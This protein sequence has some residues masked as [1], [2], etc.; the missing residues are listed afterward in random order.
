AKE[1]ILKSRPD[2]EPRPEVDLPAA[3]SG[4]PRE[5]IATMKNSQGLSEK[6]DKVFVSYSHKDKKLFEEFK[7]MLA[8]A[9]RDATV[10]LWDNTRI[11]PGAKWKEEIQMALGSAKV[12]V[13]LGE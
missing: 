5:S 13:L 2:Q 3:A 4:H 10:D 8:P 9:I 1:E 7:T 12:A 6:R 11:N